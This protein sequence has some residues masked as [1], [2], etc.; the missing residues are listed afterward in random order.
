MENDA[1]LRRVEEIKKKREEEELARKNE[2]NDKLLTEKAEI[3]LYFEKINFIEEITDHID[4]SEYIKKFGIYTDKN[5]IDCFYNP[6]HL[7]NNKN[8]L[9]I[10]NSRGGGGGESAEQFHRRYKENPDLGFISRNYKLDYLIKIIK[11]TKEKPEYIEKEKNRKIIN[12][13]IIKINEELIKLFKPYIV[14]IFTKKSL[15]QLIPP[16]IELGL[17]PIEELRKE[18]TKQNNN[19]N[20][21][22]YIKNSLKKIQDRCND[23]IILPDIPI[24]IITNQGGNS[25]YIKQTTWEYYDQ[26]HNIGYD[27][28]ID[29]KIKITSIEEYY[30]KC[31]EFELLS[32]K[33]LLI[34][35]IEDYDKKLDKLIEFNNEKEL[36]NMNIEYIKRQNF[37]NSVNNA[38]I[39]FL[40]NSKS[41][42]F[43]K[44]S[45]ENYENL[46]N[47]SFLNFNSIEWSHNKINFNNGNP[48]IDSCYGGIPQ[49]YISYYEESKVPFL[50][51]CPICNSLTKFNYLHKA[52]GSPWGG[53]GGSSS[54]CSF[55]EVYCD[56]HYF[57]VISTNKHYIITNT[58]GYSNIDL[59]RKELGGNWYYN[60]WSPNVGQPN[61][62]TQWKEWN[63]KD[64]DGKKA[65]E[66]KKR[67]EAEQ[68]QK[69][70][71]ELQ[72]KLVQLKN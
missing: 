52:Y 6:T 34:N 56:N 54:S 66:E 46:N 51:K 13:K 49:N 55:N 42:T 18:F 2:L 1:V 7:C 26:S 60:C 59:K 58:K 19:Q 20:W 27:K 47:F 32:Y 3:I 12:Q 29:D 48:Y 62:R 25:C 43:I 39:N 65:D 45:I 37:I 36:N 72:S 57:Y 11:S 33:Q 22:E 10:K 16:P 35:Q 61:N 67:I 9:I 70:I 50:T 4:I 17:T 40:K 23:K 68:I 31:R 63:P 41:N 69:Q 53:L 38:C 8:S 30:N 14:P 71:L 44:L 64:P 21:F 5:T 15:L 28:T 24:T